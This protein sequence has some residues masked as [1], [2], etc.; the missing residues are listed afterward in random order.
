[1][2]KIDEYGVI[3]NGNG[4][5]KDLFVGMTQI[6]ANISPIY[7]CYMRL[8]RMAGLMVLPSFFSVK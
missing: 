8:S 7:V 1:M 4:E 3:Q 2:Q 6:S 5:K